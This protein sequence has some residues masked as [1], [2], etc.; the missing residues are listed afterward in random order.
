MDNTSLI[1]EAQRSVVD[2][3]LHVFRIMGEASGLFSKEDN[4]KAVLVT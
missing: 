3:V 2:R 1:V 4:V